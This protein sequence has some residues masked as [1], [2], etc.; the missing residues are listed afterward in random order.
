[1]ATNKF[2]RNLPEDEASALLSLLQVTA[3][4]GRYVK[5][6]FKTGHS[7]ALFRSGRIA[8]EVPGVLR[9]TRTVYE[10]IEAWLKAE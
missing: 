7:V 1:M 10:N 2:F 5:V 3:A 9:P 6:T 4:R 8:A